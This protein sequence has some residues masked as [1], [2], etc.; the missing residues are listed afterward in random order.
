M[1]RGEYVADEPD[2]PL[3]DPVDKAE[4]AHLVGKCSERLKPRQRCSRLRLGMLVL[5]KHM[6]RM[7]PSRGAP[8]EISLPNSWAAPFRFG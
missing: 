7:R 2:G 6:R 1:Y 4:E 5:A 3:K 8:A